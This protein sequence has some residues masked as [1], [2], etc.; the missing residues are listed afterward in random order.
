MQDGV[1]TVV[2]EMPER[3]I[4]FP[5]RARL[6]SWFGKNQASARELWIGFYKKGTGTPS[7]TYL[8]ALE[9][10]LCVGWIDGVR[11][12]VDDERYVNRF[13]PRKPGSYWSAVNTKRAAE[14]KKQGLMKPAGLAAFE[15][16]DPERTKKY[17]FEREAAALPRA[18]ERTFRA[19]RR[20]WEFFQAQPP[21]Y[22]KVLTWWIVS[23]V[24]E[25]TRLTRLET[26]MRASA[27]G[28]RLQ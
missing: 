23:A 15:A 12:R 1:V 22:R 19:N 2:K 21:S 27:A 17:S 20:A 14:L 28:K 11:R 6:R 16:R 4:Y 7:V 25:E 5:S 9:E 3:C 13:T 18:L 8:E 10:A 24:K 26:L